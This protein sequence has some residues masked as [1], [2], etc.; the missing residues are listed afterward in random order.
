MYEGKSLL[1]VKIRDISVQ[2]LRELMTQGVKVTVAGFYS[3]EHAPKGAKYVRVPSGRVY[4]L[5]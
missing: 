5:I 1:N 2:E 4:R 3:P